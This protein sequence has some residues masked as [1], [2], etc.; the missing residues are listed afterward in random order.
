MTLDERLDAAQR[1]HLYSCRDVAAA[2][3]LTADAERRRYTAIR[4]LTELEA[5]VRAARIAETRS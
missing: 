4:V 5:E 2:R 3:A 1:E